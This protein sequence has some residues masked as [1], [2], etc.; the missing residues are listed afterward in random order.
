VA[1]V[2]SP[3]MYVCLPFLISV[4]YVMF[5]GD[6]VIP[7]LLLAYSESA[8]WVLL[9]GQLLRSRVYWLT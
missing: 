1:S 6:A 4:Q 9:V 3:G 5:I 8:L 2:D 7:L